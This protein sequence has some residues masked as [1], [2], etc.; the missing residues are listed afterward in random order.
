M[1]SAKNSYFIAGTDTGVG[2]TYLSVLLL[3]AFNQA[4]LKTVGLKP[5][6]TGGYHT[7]LGWRHPDA[8]ALQR[9]AS[10]SLA[11]EQVN[12]V[13]LAAPIAPH[14]AAAHSSLTLTVEGLLHR[15][16]PA[17]ACVSDVVVIEGVGGWQVPLNATETMADF[18]KALGATVILVVG[19]RLGCL[20]H[21]LLT[22][23]AIRARHIPWGGW[24][25]NCIDPHMRAL[26]D[27]IE[28]LRERLPVPLL[29]SIGI[30]TMPGVNR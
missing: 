14:I 28:A 27:N 17:L 20:N 1:C 2:K 9:E 5:L 29:G 10:V 16:S 13:C 12:P 8:L 23:E 15:C 25:A 22:A 4:G 6:A 7:P 19:M 26:E 21:A 30:S 18:V 24:I 3:R 11:Y